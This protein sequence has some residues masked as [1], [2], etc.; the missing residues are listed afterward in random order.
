MRLPDG[1]DIP[2]HR[3]LEARGPVLSV[4][5]GESIYELDIRELPD[6]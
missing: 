2:T 3:A 1:D 4:V 5:V 6:D